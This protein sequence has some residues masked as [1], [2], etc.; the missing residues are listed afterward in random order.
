MITMR[1]KI[2]VSGSPTINST[3]LKTLRAFVMSSSKFPQILGKK[4]SFVSLEIHFLKASNIKLLK[5]SLL[6][7]NTIFLLLL[8]QPLSTTFNCHM[9]RKFIR[10]SIP[11]SYD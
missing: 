8:K 3:K 10:S 7:I 9:K 5:Y 2:Q 11:C 1:Q 4:Y 6:Q